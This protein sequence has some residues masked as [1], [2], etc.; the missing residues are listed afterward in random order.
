MAEEVYVKR[1]Q[2]L[3]QEGVDEIEAVADGSIEPG[4]SIYYEPVFRQH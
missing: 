4:E 3:H 1:L 2:G